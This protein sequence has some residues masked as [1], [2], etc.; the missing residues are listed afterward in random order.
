MRLCFNDPAPMCSARVFPVPLLHSENSNRS[1]VTGGTPRALV[2]DGLPFLSGE[3]GSHDAGIDMLWRRATL[4]DEI[5]GDGATVS[6][7]LTRHRSGALKPVSPML[8]K[9][10][11]NDLLEQGWL[12]ASL[13]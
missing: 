13:H 5:D 3:H 1:V 7:K 11:E 4:S 2:S 9:E 12:S 8:F 6:S 10:W